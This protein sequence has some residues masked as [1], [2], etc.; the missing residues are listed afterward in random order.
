MKQEIK[1]LTARRD[2]YDALYETRR[3]VRMIE[4]MRPTTGDFNN[5]IFQGDKGID[6]ENAKNEMD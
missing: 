5:S 6:D 3:Y 1:Q 2:K 4:L